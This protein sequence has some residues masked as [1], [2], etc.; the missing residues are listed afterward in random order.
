M[1]KAARFWRKFPGDGMHGYKKQISKR[2]QYR[3][4]KLSHHVVE[5]KWGYYF[6]I[7]LLVISNL[8]HFLED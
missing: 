5:K 4:N 8:N 1:K 7:I 6:G 2:K 3:E